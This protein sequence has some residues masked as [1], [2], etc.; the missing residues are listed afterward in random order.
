MKKERTEIAVAHLRTNTGQLD[1]WLPSNPRQWTQTDIDRT[2]ASIRE[3]ADFLE[4]RP[5]LVVSMPDTPDFLVFAGNLRLEGCKAVKRAKVPCVVYVPES[6]EDRATI[7]RRAMKDNGSFGAWDFDALANEWDDLPLAD[8]GIE[9]PADWTKDGLST[10]GREKGEGYDEFLDKF[11][12][13]LTTDDC[14]TPPPVFDALKEWVDRRLTPLAGRKIVRPFF[15]G[16]DYEHHD[17]PE[18]CIV[19]DN[20]P[21]SI[22]AQAVRFYLSRGIDFV[23]FGQGMTIKVSGA[24]VTYIIAGATI[25]F[26]NKASILCSFVTNLAPN[27]ERIIISPELRKALEKASDDFHHAGAV[28]LPKYKMPAE[29]W[30]AATLQ[31]IAKGDE[32]VTFAKDELAEVRQIAALEAIGK[33]LYGGGWLF[34]AAAAAAAA[35]IEADKQIPLELSPEERAIVASLG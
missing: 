8:W 27:G 24:D 34:S 18:G 3:D 10:A 11:A 33:S 22:Y 16:G 2:A 30:T 14:Y 12:T 15:P 23:L 32:E 25:E 7:K 29:L 9:A 26:E 4:D 20:P 19:I 1:T 28:E 31:K 17:Y 5:L 35:A 21:F 13:H 6:D